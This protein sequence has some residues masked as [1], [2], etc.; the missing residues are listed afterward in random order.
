MAQI[1]FDPERFRSACRKVADLQEQTGFMENISVGR[2]RRARTRSVSREGHTNIGG[3]SESSLH[4]I[5]KYYIEENSDFHEV[6]CKI[7]TGCLQRGHR[8]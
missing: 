5:L 3:L 2:N 6:G 1:A 7:S 8:L 4:L